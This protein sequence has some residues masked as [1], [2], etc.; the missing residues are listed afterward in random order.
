MVHFCDVDARAD[1]QHAAVDAA[2]GAAE[3]VRRGPFQSIT[4]TSHA[5]PCGSL[6]LEATQNYSYTGAASR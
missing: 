3:V 5:Q 6:W 1:Q 2:V 4:I